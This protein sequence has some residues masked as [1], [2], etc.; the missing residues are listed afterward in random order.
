MTVSERRDWLALILA[1]GVGPATIN[2]L[3]ASFGDVG[4]ARVAGRQDL[5][6]AGLSEEAADAVL[7]P[8]QAR[9]EACEAWLDES[10]EHHLLTLSSPD[11]PSQLYSLPQ[12]PAALFV[13]GRVSL[14]S[15]WQLAI[16][17]SRNPTAGGKENAYAFARH[18]AENGLV[19]T[20]GMALGID[21]AAHL[22]AL[23][24]GKPTVAVTG[25]GLDRVYPA[26]HHDLAHRIAGQGVLVSEFAPGSR[27][28]PQ[29]FPQRNRI[30]A[31]LS[32]GTLV[33][34]AAP[35]SGS[36]ITAYQALEQSREVFA[37]P[38]SIHNPMARGCHQ[39]IREGAKLVENS[40]DILSELA[41]LAGAQAALKSDDSGPNDSLPVE[42]SHR[43]VLEA[44][45][46]DP[47]SINMLAERTSLPV[48]TISSVL[49]IL[50]MQGL[51]SAEDGGRYI[52]IG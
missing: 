31:G 44:M 1:P 43:V 50:E 5:L 42:D 22:G 8:D 17:G 24:A 38:G 2:R 48:N 49:L 39:L 13:K 32:L 41:P 28:L 16:V 35:K 19:I 29:H 51:V 14:L 10:S 6:H 34:E 12:P 46:H 37:I 11:Y 33:V 21:A 47:V 9:L 23:D 3:L 4:T 20:S 27:P 25:N 40:D 26:R 18:L 52:R 7:Q 15:E 45:A 36:L 30:I